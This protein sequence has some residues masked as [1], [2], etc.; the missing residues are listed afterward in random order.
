MSGS[1]DFFYFLTNLFYS[2]EPNF[3]LIQ[4]H[5]NEKKIPKKIVI[6]KLLGIF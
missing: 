4:C 3:F 1:E 2:K 5:T 6:Q